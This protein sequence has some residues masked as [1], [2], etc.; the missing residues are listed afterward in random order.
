MKSEAT[1]QNRSELSVITRAKDLC[2]YVMTITD[3]SPKR[4]RFTLVSR[5]QNYALDTTE[6]LIMANE[7]FVSRETLLQRRKGLDISGRR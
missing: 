5:L 6:Y 2:S 7:V 4:F 3:K 1:M